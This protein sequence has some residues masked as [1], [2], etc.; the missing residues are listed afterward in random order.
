MCRF[1]KWFVVVICC[2][3]VWIGASVDAQQPSKGIVTE[4]FDWDTYKTLTE[5]TLAQMSLDD[6]LLRA[7]Y[8]QIFLLSGK[9]TDWELAVRSDL[10]R[11]GNAATPVLLSLFEENPESEFRAE[12]MGKIEI[13]P[14]VDL[15][16][17]LNATR[18]LFQKE[19]LKLPPRTC[20]Q[21]AWLLERHGTATDFRILEQL[22][23]HPVKEVGFV[24]KPNIERMTKRL[25]QESGSKQA[26][27]QIPLT[28][29]AAST[30]VP[31][32]PHPITTAAASPLATTPALQTP[33]LAIERKAPV[34]PWVVGIAA[35]TVIA[36]L[37][38]KRRA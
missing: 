5:P 7:A 29:P 24:I 9:P 23:N 13:I 27:V 18:A 15:E 32:T 20:Y 38:W 8:A 2:Q 34:W 36:L 10:L 4:R 17:F 37:V 22:R 1:L 35:L 30:P 6:P 33:A 16:P 14:T 12:L 26:P 19:G 25:A 21:M 31:S 11:R 28:T 3:A